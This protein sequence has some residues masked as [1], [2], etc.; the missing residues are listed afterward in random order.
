MTTVEIQNDAW[1]RNEH[2]NADV[3]LQT[4]TKQNNLR[5]EKIERAD[6]YIETFMILIWM[7]GIGLLWVFLESRFPSL[8]LLWNGLVLIAFVYFSMVLLWKFYQLWIEPVAY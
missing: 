5:E 4:K 3:M 8:Y 2:Y 6:L 7:A 1:I